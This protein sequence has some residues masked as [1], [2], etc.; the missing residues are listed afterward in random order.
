MKI[1]LLTVDVEQPQ[2]NSCI[3]RFAF[4][5]PKNGQFND[6]INSVLGK[7][8]ESGELHKTR[9]KWA[10]QGKLSVHKISTDYLLS[11]QT[12]GGGKG[13]PLG[14]ENTSPAFLIYLAGFTASWLVLFGEI[15]V[16]KATEEQ[17]KDVKNSHYWIKENGIFVQKLNYY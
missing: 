15:L 6:L 9:L 4:A 8:V 5:L 17:R 10:A 16:K 2:I 14:F 7:M 12:C 1:V 13:R 11:G 3:H